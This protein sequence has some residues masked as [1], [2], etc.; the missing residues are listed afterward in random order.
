MLSLIWKKG[1]TCFE[2]LITIL[3]L[4]FINSFMMAPAFKIFRDVI[5]HTR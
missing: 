2:F 4:L 3:T 1:H 5:A